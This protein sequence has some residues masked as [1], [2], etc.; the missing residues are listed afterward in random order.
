M[1]HLKCLLCSFSPRLLSKALESMIEPSPEQTQPSIH[2]GGGKRRLSRDDNVL[3]KR[4]KQTATEGIS[5]KNATNA[6]E[7]SMNVESDESKAN[8]QSKGKEMTQRRQC[9]VCT[10][11]EFVGRSA[12]DGDSK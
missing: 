10:E 4:P 6:E 12:K 5:L 11:E 1:T 9:M 8:V 7:H 2:D 3:A